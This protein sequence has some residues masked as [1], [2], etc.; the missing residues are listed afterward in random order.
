MWI[1]KQEREN[2]QV[3]IRRNGQFASSNIGTV[4]SL[5][6]E[7]GWSS[8]TGAMSACCRNR[9]AVYLLDGNISEAE[10]WIARAK[11]IR[12]IE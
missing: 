1:A 3:A 6:F 2:Y 8:I 4:M 11:A 10:R 7:W 5:I 9:A 12:G